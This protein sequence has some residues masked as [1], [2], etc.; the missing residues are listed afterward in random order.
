MAGLGLVENNCN[1][2]IG[3]IYLLKGPLHHWGQSVLLN[4]QS[5]DHHLSLHYRRSAIRLIHIA[6]PKPWTEKILTETFQWDCST[7]NFIA[8]KVTNFNVNTF[9]RYITANWRKGQLLDFGAF[10]LDLKKVVPG[11]S[12]EGVPNK[13]KARRYKPYTHVTH[14]KI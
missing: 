4:L 9:G 1:G 11:R 8:C 2:M 12:K 6:L 14:I 13:S 3:G 7:W 5:T 10:I